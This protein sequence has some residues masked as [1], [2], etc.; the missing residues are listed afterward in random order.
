V[1]CKPVKPVHQ[2]NAVTATQNSEAILPSQDSEAILND[3]NMQLRKTELHKLV[4]GTGKQFTTNAVSMGDAFYDHTLTSEHVWMC[5]PISSIRRSVEHYHAQKLLC[6]DNNA[7]ILVPKWALREHYALSAMQTLATYPKGYHL[8]TDS[9]GKSVKGL[10]WPAVVLYDPPRPEIP[11]PPTRKLAML[12]K[13]R[14]SS[15]Y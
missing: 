15:L 4:R 1:D 8:F 6:N 11:A 9:S 12:Y 10:P 5:P 14:G 3:A 7:C 13:C 2:L